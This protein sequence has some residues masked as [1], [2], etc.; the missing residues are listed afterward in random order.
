[1]VIDTV[2]LE[3]VVAE[4]AP[5]DSGQSQFVR[6]FK[7]FGHLHDLVTAF[8]R[9]EINGSPH[10]GGPHIPRFLDSP[11][12]DLV[13]GIGIRQQ[14]VVID[15]HYERDLVG[16]FPGHGSQY[17]ESGRHCIAVG[18]EGQL[19][20]ILGIKVK[21]IGGK[22]GARCMFYSLV[23][24]QDGQVAG[25]GKAPMPISGRLHRVPWDG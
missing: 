20:N 4:V 16:I 7:C 25:I 22:R 24:G 11:E 3:G 18:F 10:G 17:P 5:Q 19:H 1:M 12:K 21:G 9:P 23:D 8:F 14:F 6:I 2:F 15:F 13:V